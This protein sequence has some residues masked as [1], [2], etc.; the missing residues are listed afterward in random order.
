M[1]VRIRSTNK[2]V[3]LYHQSAARFEEHVFAMVISGNTDILMLTPYTSFYE[4][5]D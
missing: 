1:P 3:E 5:N 4:C 2:Y